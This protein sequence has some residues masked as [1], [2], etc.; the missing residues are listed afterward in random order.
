MLIIYIETPDG[1]GFYDGAN[2][3][4]GPTLLTN[5]DVRSFVGKLTELIHTDKITSFQI[6]GDSHASIQ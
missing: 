4:K 3:L 1:N 6:F 2:I 5:S